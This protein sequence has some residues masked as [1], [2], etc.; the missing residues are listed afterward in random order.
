MSNAFSVNIYIAEESPSK[1]MICVDS[2]NTVQIGVDHF[3]F[4][5]IRN[6]QLMVN[7][8]IDRIKRDR[9]F[10]GQ[11]YSHKME[12]VDLLIYALID[13]VSSQLYRVGVLDF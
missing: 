2:L 13:R 1:Q 3:Q 4:V 8:L 9:T 6:L 12:Q 7:E 10:F 11:L 5:Q